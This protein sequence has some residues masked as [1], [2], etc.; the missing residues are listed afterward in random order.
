MDL[1]AIAD[2][3]AGAYV[4]TLEA[5]RERQYISELEAQNVCD[6]LK[7]MTG[8]EYKLICQLVLGQTPAIVVETADGE[9]KT[10][11]A[12]SV[13]TFIKEG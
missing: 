7:R 9:Q 3:R 10:L 5:Q 13:R 1:S 6:K 8:K 4:K 11:T 12:A 2:A